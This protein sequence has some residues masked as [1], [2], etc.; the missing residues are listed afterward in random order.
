MLRWL[1]IS[2]KLAAVWNFLVFLQRGVYQTITE[3]LLGIQAMFPSRQGI[4]QV[5]KS[6]LQQ[7]YHYYRIQINMDWSLKLVLV[8]V[9]MTHIHTRISLISLY[10]PINPQHVTV[11]KIKLDPLQNYRFTINFLWFWY[12][13]NSLSV[14]VFHNILLVVNVNS[15]TGFSNRLQYYVKYFFFRSV[16]NTWPGNYFGMD[17]R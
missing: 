15:F 3:R 7:V 1:D 16:L 14:V 4:R 6:I 10:S 17:S 8:H 2:L 11:N 13:R 5:G 12:W 9:F